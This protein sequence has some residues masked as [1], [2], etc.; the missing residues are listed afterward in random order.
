MQFDAM[1]PTATPQEITRELRR[2]H[3]CMQVRLISPL[4]PPPPTVIP[5]GCP[6]HMYGASKWDILPCWR[7]RTRW[8]PTTSRRRWGCWRARWRRG[9]ACCTH[10]TCCCRC[11]AR[12]WLRCA[13]CSLAFD[14]FCAFTLE[15]LHIWAETTLI[16]VILLMFW[17]LKIH[18][19]DSETFSL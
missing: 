14:V 9:A 6:L 12:P 7:H 5:P 2:A 1:L 3:I 19:R 11:G 18:I 16:L 8:R 10:G 13:P 4:C 17:P 15:E